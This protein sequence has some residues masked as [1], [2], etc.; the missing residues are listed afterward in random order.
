MDLIRKYTI[1]QKYQILPNASL[2]LAKSK[3]IFAG[4]CLIL[5]ASSSKLSFSTVWKE[6]LSN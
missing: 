2:L 1:L 4:L 6:F 5:L 3:N